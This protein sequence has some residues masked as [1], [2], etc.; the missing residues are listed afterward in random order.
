MFLFCLFFSSPLLSFFKH[1]KIGQTFF[2]SLPS[3]TF[4]EICLIFFYLGA[5]IKFSKKRFNVFFS[6]MFF[7]PPSLIRFCFFSDLKQRN[8]S[9]WPNKWVYHISLMV[10][11]Y[12]LHHCSFFNPFS[13]GPSL[14]V[15]I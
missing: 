10:N 8:K 2:I 15:R 12:I 13:A 14:F 4:L 3:L 6:Q 9:Q 5:I 11:L 1:I 7:L